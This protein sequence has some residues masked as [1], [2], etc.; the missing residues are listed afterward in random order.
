MLAKVQERVTHERYVQ[1]DP[2]ADRKESIRN[3]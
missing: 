2:I 3:V 1:S